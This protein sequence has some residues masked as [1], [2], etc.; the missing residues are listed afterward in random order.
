MKKHSA[1]K[2]S[3]ISQNIFT[4][5]GAEDAKENGTYRGSAR[6]IAEQR[7]GTGIHRGDAE[8]RRRGEEVGGWRETTTLPTSESRRLWTQTASPL[9]FICDDQVYD[10]RLSRSPDYR[11]AVALNVL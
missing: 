11:V 2:R 4:A 1:V 6:M 3:V 5:K 7:T 9:I 10:D 8:A